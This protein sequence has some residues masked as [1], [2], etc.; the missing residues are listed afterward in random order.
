[1][2]TSIILGCLVSSNILITFKQLASDCSRI[3]VLIVQSKKLFLIKTITG[4]DGNN[5]NKLY[6][7]NTKAKNVQ[8][9]EGHSYRRIS[10]YDRKLLFL[11]G[12][13]LGFSC[14]LSKF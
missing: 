14:S 8:R 2:I 10:S 1:V 6:F 3:I 9:G 11:V 7:K 12:S 5:L 13:P 4:P